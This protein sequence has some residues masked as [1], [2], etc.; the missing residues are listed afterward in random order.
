MHPSM[1]RTAGFG[2]RLWFGGVGCG[3]GSNRVVWQ[4]CVRQGVWEG[5]VCGGVYTP[6]QIACW[7]T[8]P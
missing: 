8:P 6:C 2:G 3:G 1:M 5:G 7:D 4:G